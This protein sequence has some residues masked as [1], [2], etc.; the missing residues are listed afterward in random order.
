MTD[1]CTGVSRCSRALPPPHS[2][3]STEYHKTR[4]QSSCKRHIHSPS[5]TAVQCRGEK[6]WNPSFPPCSKFVSAL[7][8]K[9]R[10]ATGARHS[11]VIITIN[12][13]AAFLLYEKTFMSEV[14]TLLLVTNDMNRPQS[15]SEKISES[16]EGRCIWAGLS[17]PH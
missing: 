10:W 17:R 1:A 5:L 11:D 15:C 8:F 12:L 3:R 4:N 14:T 13:K 7:T 2:M 6:L 9:N 16:E